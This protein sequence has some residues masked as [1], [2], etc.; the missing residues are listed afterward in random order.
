[1]H[2]SGDLVFLL[3]SGIHSAPNSLIAKRK[4]YPA[5]SA[6]NSLAAKRLALL[7]VR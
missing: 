3:L 7:G 1:M 5:L 2:P 4:I 6:V